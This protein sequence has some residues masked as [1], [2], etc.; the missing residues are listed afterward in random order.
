MLGTLLGRIKLLYLCF[1]KCKEDKKEVAEEVCEKG[2][3]NKGEKE[4]DVKGEQEELFYR[5]LVCV[6]D[7]ALD[8]DNKGFQKVFGDKVNVLEMSDEQKEK[9][10]DKK[11]RSKEVLL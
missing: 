5:L 1:E 4:K 2:D 10:K 9:D 3:G 11:K 8:R 6:L 7:Q